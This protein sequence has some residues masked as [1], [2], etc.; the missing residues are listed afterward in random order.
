MNVSKELIKDLDEMYSI[1]YNN[2]VSAWL[3]TF[4]KKST[5]Q[6]MHAITKLITGESLLEH[7]HNY[8]ASFTEYHPLGAKYNKTYNCICGCTLCDALFKLT[9]KPTNRTLMVGSICLT[10]YF[11]KYFNSNLI[12]GKNNGFCKQ[13]LFPLIKKGK[14]KNI[15][16]TIPFLCNNCNKPQ[17]NYLNISY[18]E[19]E[20][21]KTN[22]DI[23]WNPF[24]IKKWS[25]FGLF[26]NIPEGLLSRV[27]STK[28]I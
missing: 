21:F 6:D 20:E 3:R 9:H 27:I 28:I 18:A 12:C 17:K 15:E 26:T 8:S 7:P 10:Q 5:K 24:P 4:S 25:W 2:S 23:C 19:R 16:I 22:Y 1:Q 13:C 11:N 14:R